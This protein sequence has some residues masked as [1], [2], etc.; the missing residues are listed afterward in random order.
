[1]PAQQPS[2]P[3]SSQSQRRRGGWFPPCVQLSGGPTTQHKLGLPGTQPNQDP[4]CQP[5]QSRHL[6]PKLWGRFW[7][8]FAGKSYLASVAWL[9][10]PP[11]LRQE[12]ILHSCWDSLQACTET[13]AQDT[14]STGYLSFCSSQLLLILPR[15]CACTCEASEFVVTAL[16]PKLLQKEEGQGS[17]CSAVPTRW[18]CHPGLLGSFCK[19]FVVLQEDLLHGNLGL[20][21]IFSCIHV[22]FIVI[23]VNCPVR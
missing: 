10:P 21:A 12:P 13:L 1:M 14:C 20:W 17:P 22:R 6:I 23:L 18:Y 11:G 2:L 4:A 19:V 5:C 3:P 7:S 8:A 16:S 9:H 15:L